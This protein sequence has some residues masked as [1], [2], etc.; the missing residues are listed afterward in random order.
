MDIKEGKYIVEAKHLI[1]NW[2]NKEV[3]FEEGN[4]YKGVYENEYWTIYNNS[5]NLTTYNEINM[6]GKRLIDFNNDFKIIKEDN[7]IEVK[8]DIVTIER[9]SCSNMITVKVKGNESVWVLDDGV[10]RIAGNIRDL[11]E[12][13]GIKSEIVD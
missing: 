13:L 11:L 9:D 12:E 4:L 5:N 10:D 8:E 3:L 1:L 7:S 2:N 6:I